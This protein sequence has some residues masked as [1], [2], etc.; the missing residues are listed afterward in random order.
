[1][2]GSADLVVGAQAREAAGELDVVGRRRP[3]TSAASCRIC[4][5]RPSA[6]PLTADRPETANWLA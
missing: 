2:N 5:A 4:A 3:S 6:A 1:M